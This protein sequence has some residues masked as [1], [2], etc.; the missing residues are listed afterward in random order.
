[1]NKQE[2]IHQLKKELQGLMQSDIDD[3]IR[4]QEEYF[5]EAASSGRDEASVIHSLGPPAALAKELKAEYQIKVA[6]NESKIPAK[7]KGIFK[8]ILALCV[9]APFNLIFI[10]GPFLAVC[11]FLFAFWV[12]D[13]VFG[14][15][16]LAGIVASL[17]VALMISPLVGIT[18]LFGGLTVFGFS[19]LF[20]CAM[21]YATSGFMKVMVSFLKWNINFVTGA[22]K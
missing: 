17:A 9:L 5:R 10:L 14:V 8:A 12:V 20:F 19:L 3:I 21:Y 7:I 18:G 11:G 4:D 13:A 2:Y 22:A 6:A 15:L 1:M 16:S